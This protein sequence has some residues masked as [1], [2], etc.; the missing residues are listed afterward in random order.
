VPFVQWIRLGSS[1]RV[2][3]G[4]PCRMADEIQRRRD[5]FGH[6]YVTVNALYLDEFAPVVELLHGR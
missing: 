2:S 4:T 5:L 1:R 6:S 3:R